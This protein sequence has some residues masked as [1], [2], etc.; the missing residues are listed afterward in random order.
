MSEQ[1]SLEVVIKDTDMETD[2]QQASVDIAKDAANK[3]AI[4]KDIAAYIKKEMDI[5]YKPSWHCI[6]GRDYGRQV[7]V[8]FFL[9]TRNHELGYLTRPSSPF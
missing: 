2:M 9:R 1:Q 8:K 3:Y 5:K 6:V 4:E 7:F